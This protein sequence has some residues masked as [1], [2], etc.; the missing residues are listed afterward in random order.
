MH[1]LKPIRERLG[2][3]QQ[4]LAEG[5]GCTQGNVGHYEKGQTLPPDMASKLIA[6]ATARGLPIGFDHVYGGAKLPKPAKAE[7]DIA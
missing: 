2:V 3:T 5:L 4:V 1:H 6:F 7:R